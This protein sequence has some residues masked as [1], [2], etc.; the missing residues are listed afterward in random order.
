ML[1]KIECVAQRH[2]PRGA[3]FNGVAQKKK[4]AIN[5]NP[6]PA[7]QMPDACDPESE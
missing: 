7:I 5:L 2:F 6:V 1:G 4:V 3:K